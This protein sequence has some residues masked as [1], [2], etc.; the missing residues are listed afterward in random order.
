MALSFSKVEKS[1]STCAPFYSDDVSTY[2]DH[3][4]ILKIHSVCTSSWP[5]QEAVFTSHFQCRLQF[6]QIRTTRGDIQCKRPR[7]LRIG[8]RVLIAS[9]GGDFRPIFAHGCWCRCWC[10]CGLL[11]ELKGTKWS[12]ARHSC[13]CHAHFVI[14]IKHLQLAYKKTLLPSIHASLSPPFR[15]AGRMDSKREKKFTS[16][17]LYP[18]QKYRTSRGTFILQVQDNFFQKQERNL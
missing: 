10:F 8:N 4:F 15:T 5:A 13:Q 1:T 16:A 3:V 14:S 7:F 17:L 12:H 18:L 2:F 6:R 9:D 11:L